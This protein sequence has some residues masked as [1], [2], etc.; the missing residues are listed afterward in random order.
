M[1]TFPHEIEGDF[2]VS[3]IMDDARTRTR[4]TVGQLIQTLD[5]QHILMFLC[6]NSSIPVSGI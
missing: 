5:Y 1:L 2:G 3:T 6:F 4:T